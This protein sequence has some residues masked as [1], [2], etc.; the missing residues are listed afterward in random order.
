MNESY[1]RALISLTRSTSEPTLNAVVDHLC[2]GKTQEQAAEKQ[3]V[4]QEAVA[5]LTTRIKNLDALVTEISSL[6]NNS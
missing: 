6:K 4:K 5:R 2:Y 3:G 1:I